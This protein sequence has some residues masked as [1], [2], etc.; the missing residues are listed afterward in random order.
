MGQLVFKLNKKYMS[1]QIF[2]F[3]TFLFI[4]LLYGVITAYPVMWLWNHCLVPAVSSGLKTITFWQALGIRIL[5]GLLFH[6][7]VK[8]DKN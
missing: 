3:F 1:K 8:Q 5:A 6:T 7:T 4:I 2:A